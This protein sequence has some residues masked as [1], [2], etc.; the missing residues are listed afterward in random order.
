MRDLSAIERTIRGKPIAS[1]AELQAYTYEIPEGQAPP[2]LLNRF[3][4]G[5]EVDPAELFAAL[6]T[7]GRSAAGDSDAALEIIETIKRRLSTTFPN[8]VPGADG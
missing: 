4:A 5:E 3:V 2:Q 8:D 6:D 7:E 1:L